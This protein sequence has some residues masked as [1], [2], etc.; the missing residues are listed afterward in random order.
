M[1]KGDGS[2]SKQEIKET[3]EQEAMPKRLRPGMIALWALLALAL[4]GGLLWLI[5]RPR[6]NFSRMEAVKSFPVS[7]S[8]QARMVSYGEGL[9]RYSGDG[10]SYLNSQGL[11]QWNISCSMNNPQLVMQGDYGALT[12]VSGQSVVV[13]NQKGEVGRYTTTDPIM[14]AA[15]SAGGVTTVALERDL[16]SLVCFYDKFG[17]KLDIEISLEM[18]ESGYPMAMALSPEGSGLV[19][20]MV[21]SKG[22]SLNSQLVFYNFTVG[23]SEANRLIGFFSHEGHLLPQIDYL[24]SKRV[25][26]VTD[27]GLE[28]YS[29]DQENKPVLLETIPFPG[30]VSAYVVENRHI[31]F[32]F[33]EPGSGNNTLHVYDENGK[34]QF[35]KEAGNGVRKLQL[36]SDLVLL[37]R[38]NQLQLWDYK[39]NSYFSGSL[40][41][42][43]AYLFLQGKKMLQLEGGQLNHIRF[44]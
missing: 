28:V 36:G 15:V 24:G 10:I 16:N 37:Q 12:D 41:H 33:A 9:L 44:R 32:L 3:K 5:L 26:A 29:L 42:P 14:T 17:L 20:S 25:A 23:R 38:E 13:F 18:S 21:S 39:G 2:V 19:M 27:A 1:I 8:G 4:A 7:V 22:G 30:E 34:L 31:A 40:D 11:E 6:G 35:S 43:N